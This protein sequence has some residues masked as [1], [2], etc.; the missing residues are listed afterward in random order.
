MTATNIFSAYLRL[1]QLPDEIKTAN[2]IKL[3][4]K[5]P[6][7]DVTHIAGY[8]KPLESLKN[9]KGQIVFYLN[10]TRGVINSPDNRRA[11][12]FLMAKDS[13]NFSSIYL[14]NNSAPNTD[15]KLIG[16]GTP[17]RQK[18]FGRKKITNPFYECKDDGFLFVISPDWRVIEVLIIPDGGNTILGNAQALFDG[19][20]NKALETI[21]ATAKTFF[22]Y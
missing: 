16:H 9:R 19:V 2:K 15:G 12:R 21:R 10:E 4:A 5:V 13:L 11:D 18:T 22:Q 17:N 7:Y 20:Y 8:Y 3:G 1:E 6:R 14:L